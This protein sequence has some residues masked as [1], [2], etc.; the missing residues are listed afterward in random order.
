MTAPI[1]GSRP[2]A[3]LFDFD[4]VILASTA[5]KAEA[6]VEV[7]RGE[8]PEALRAIRDYQE[9]H[10][11][12]GRREKF[13]HFETAIFGRAASPARIDTLCAEFARLVDSALLAVPFV[14]GAEETLVACG[15]HAAL[16]IVS[17]MPESELRIVV[18][19]RGLAEF[20]QSVVGSPQTKLD[21]FQRILDGS[22]WPPSCYLAIG[23][24]T[25]EYEAA[26]RLGI[27]FLA[28]VPPEI[29]SRFPPGTPT[30][31]TLEGLPA[32]LGFA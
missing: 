22:E 4:G 11:G 18:R 28:V 23:D 7:Y 2:A 3:I 26:T 8:R 17:G 30:V 5:L 9:A 24:A 16:H 12:I 20:F 25:T 29:D 21:A 31:A 1:S 19:K 6:F 13:V 10:G 27:P 15:S 14:A 32:W